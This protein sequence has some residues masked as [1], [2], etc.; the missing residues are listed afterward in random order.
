MKGAS[1]CA[2]AVPEGVA[3]VPGSDCSSCR[4]WWRRWPPRKRRLTPSQVLR[5]GTQVTG[6]TPWSRRWPPRKR[7]PSPSQVLRPRMQGAGRT[8]WWG[9]WWPRKRRLWPSQVLRP[10]TR[11]AGRTPWRRRR[12]PPGERRFSLSR[13]PRQAAQGSGSTPR[14][15]RRSPGKRR[16]SPSKELQ[17]SE[18]APWPY[19]LPFLADRV[20]KQG[21]T[22]PLPRGVSLVYTYV[23]RDIK[24]THGETR[25][26]RRSAAGREQLRE[27]RVD[28]PR[29]RGGGPVRRVAAALSRCLCD[30]RVRGQQHHHAG[31]RDHPSA[32]AEGRSQDIQS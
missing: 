28:E 29:E 23:Q 24:I 1:A 31:H 17:P 6:G 15:S 19:A 16:L 4:S 13:V 11:S 7:R 20:I 14:Q 21:Y 5:P 27:P 30:G 26:Q 12:W 32:D 2:K 10:R 8:H 25:R 3:C 18:P 9:R 22:L